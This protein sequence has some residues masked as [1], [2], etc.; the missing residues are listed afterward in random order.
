[1]AAIHKTNNMDQ[2]IDV[3][4]QTG[5]DKRKRYLA[6]L[7][8]LFLVGCA[9]VLFNRRRKIETGYIPIV[10][11]HRDTGKEPRKESRKE[12]EHPIIS[13]SINTEDDIVGKAFS[14]LA[15]E[16]LAPWLP[17][18]KTHI[19]QAPITNRMLCAMELA[20]RGGAFRV[21]IIGKKVYYR[22]LVMWKQ[23][24][25]KDRMVWYLKLLKKMALRGMIKKPVDVIIYV[26]D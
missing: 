5:E 18:D 2:F 14:W 26:G 6:V 17:V 24:Y 23:T 1:M 25:R 11:S 22:Q 3:S 10:P 12:P 16:Y 19:G 21:R 7:L 20:Y 13:V 4:K 15:D 9:F 8:L